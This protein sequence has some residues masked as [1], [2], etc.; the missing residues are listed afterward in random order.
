MKKLLRLEMLWNSACHD[1][2]EK[3]MAHRCYLRK[4][5]CAISAKDIRQYF[6]SRDQDSA[7]FGSVRYYW[8]IVASCSAEF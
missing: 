7:I 4:S 8:P 5:E 6:L 2:E 1:A 3:R